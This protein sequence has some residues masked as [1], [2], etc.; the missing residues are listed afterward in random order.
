MASFSVLPSTRSRRGMP[1]SARGTAFL[2]AASLAPVAGKA[3]ILSHGTLPSQC[4][5]FATC[6]L[7][8]GGN[9][10]VDWANFHALF[11]EARE[12]ETEDPQ[13]AM[14]AYFRLMDIY[15]LDAGVALRCRLGSAAVFYRLAQRYLALGF[16]QRAANL[17][18]LAMSMVWDTTKQQHGMECLQYEL[19]GVRWLEEFMDTYLK[20][21]T[22]LR[23]NDLAMLPHPSHFQV[24][25]Q[26]RNPDLKVGVFSLCDYGAES[27]MHWLLDRS[28]RN[29]EAYCTRHGYGMEWT[30]RR[31][32]SSA[33]RHPVWGQLAGPLEL[34]ESGRYDWILSMDCDSLF[35][36]MERTVDSLLY[37]FAS[38]ETP[39]GRLEFD[40]DVHFLISEDGRGLA[41]GNWIV[42]NSPQG[43]AFLRS[44]YGSEDQDSNPYLQH[45]L[46]DQFS[47]LWHL[48]RPGVSV[49][50]PPE[51]RTADVARPPQPSRWEDVGYTPLARLVPQELLLGSYPHISCSQPGDRAHRCY[52]TASE[53]AAQGSTA[54]DGDFIVSVP[55][56]GALPQQMA[57]A[58]LDRFLLESI[59][60]LGQPAYEQELRQ[61]CSSPDVSRCL[62]GA[63]G[64]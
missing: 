34:L 29:R 10:V 53:A 35:I 52:Q 59:G 49:P 41:G 55:L 24:P 12:K 28:R 25:K 5:E 61:L 9:G 22:S 48:V 11:S 51:Q 3:Q 16:S 45:D 47:L 30:S 21:A 15:T 60:A 37:R 6:S 17:F 38:R 2:V 23:R 18:Q 19:W 39:W 20:H 50:M 26:F 13:V 1:R 54:V 64:A 56:L 43:R 7:A 32:L 8:G 58:I 46:R 36:D 27:P 14:E 31:P 4:A 40:P 62:A 44:V 63:M 33:N 57:Q 42:R